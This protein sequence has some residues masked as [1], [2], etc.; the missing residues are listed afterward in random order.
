MKKFREIR[1]LIDAQL[2]SWLLEQDIPMAAPHFWACS[3]SL[4]TQLIRFAC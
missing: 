1:N 3:R 2:K 4:A